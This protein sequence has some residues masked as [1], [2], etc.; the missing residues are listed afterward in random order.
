MCH[1]N[2]RVSFGKATERASRYLL[3]QEDLPWTHDGKDG[4][5]NKHLLVR[6]HGARIEVAASER[7]CEFITYLPDMARSSI[8]GPDMRHKH[9]LTNRTVSEIC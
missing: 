6:G 5:R 2:F 8:N 1:W 4:M 7:R 9:G 3:S